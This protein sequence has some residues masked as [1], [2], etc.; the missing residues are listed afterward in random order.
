M[1]RGRRGRAL[2]RD[3]DGGGP[4]LVRDEEGRERNAAYPSLAKFKG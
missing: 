1:R 2:V 4:A 3:D